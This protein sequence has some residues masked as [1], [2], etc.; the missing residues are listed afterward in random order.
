MKRDITMELQDVY[1]KLC[2]I[3]KF[4]SNNIMES[5]HDLIG[6][7]NRAADFTQTAWEKS[8]EL[9]YDVEPEV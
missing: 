7:L 3:M 2:D 1:N 6:W 8:V 4:V 9:G 5:D